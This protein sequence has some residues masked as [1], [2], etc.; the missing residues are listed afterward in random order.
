MLRPIFLALL[1]LI[2]TLCLSLAAHPS[3]ATF[4][5]LQQGLQLYQADRFTESVQIYQQAI[6]NYA[7][8]KDRLSEALAQRYLSLAYQELGQWEPAKLAI[9]QSLK[10]LQSGSNDKAHLEVL[11]KVLNTQGRYL[12]QTGQIE[13]ALDT[14]KQST[15]AYQKAGQQSGVISSLTNQAIALQALGFT[16]QAQATLTAVRQTLQSTENS[17]LRAEGLSHLGEALRRLGDLNQS[18]QILQESLATTQD[19]TLQSKILLE[20]GNTAKVIATRN[21]VI[22]QS[23]DQSVKTALDYYQRSL[24]LAPSD[25]LKLQAQLNLFR[26]W[27]ET[28]QTKQAVQQW[29][30]IQPLFSRLAT[31]RSTIYAQLNAAQSL[32][33]LEQINPLEIAKLIK[34]AYQQAKTLQDPRTESYALGQLGELYE[35]NQ[36]WADA[37]KLTQQ[38]L[39]RIESIYAPDMQYRWEWQLGRLLK[40]QGDQQTAIAAYTRAIK[41]LQS[42][43]ENLLLINPDVQFSFRDRVEPISRDLT[44]LLLQSTTELPQFQLQSAIANIDALQLAELENFLRCDLSQLASISQDLDRIDPRAAF[45]YP[46]ILSDRI[47]VIVRFP[48]QPLKHYATRIEQS[49]VEQTLR[50]LRRAILRNNASSVIEHSKQVYRWIMKPLESDLS[51]NQS[52]ETLVFVLDGDLRNIPM[53]VLYDAE[54]NQYLVEKPYAIALLPSSQL[55]DLRT[56]PQS[57][58]VLGAGISEALQVGNRRFNALNALAELQQIQTSTSSEI[59]INQNFNQSKLQEKLHSQHFSIV[60]LVTHGNFSSDPENTY[61]LIHSSTAPE[62]ELL[63]PNDLTLLLRPKDV[64]SNLGID[65]LVLSACKTA[66]GDNRATLGLVGLAVRAGAKSTLGTLWQ[67]NDESTIALMNQFYNELKQPGISKA[68]ALHRAQLALLQSPKY[69]NPYHWSPYILVGNWR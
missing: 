68:K 32:I 67:V 28:N 16:V 37:Q 64:P 33:K 48:G 30:T 18:Q 52:L 17:D 19:P 60:H 38:A 66:E 27:V 53:T 44:D 41:A 47:E 21:R 36:Q 65:L 62:G 2:L 8:Q 46:I 14:W 57:E 55:F 39:F 15:L 25:T 35:S 43:R 56:L 50:S 54:T 31:N 29:Q 4:S 63:K 59:L 9:E 58:T 42:V 6:A 51:K 10:L 13:A 69:Q 23:P 11:A 5:L 7:Q 22:G 3:T 49:T 20:L 26:L 61:L 12:F 34:T 45:I 40:R 24:N 1:S